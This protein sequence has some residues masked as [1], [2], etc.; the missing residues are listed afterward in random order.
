[1]IVST[2][3]RVTF[4]SKNG[5]SHT[6]T[7]DHTNYVDMQRWN[8][9]HNDMMQINQEPVDHREVSYDSYKELSKLTMLAHQY[10]AQ[11]PLKRPKP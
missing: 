5:M 8:A 3:S 1:M 10:A 7:F 9:Y 11:N 6:E 4:L 2:K